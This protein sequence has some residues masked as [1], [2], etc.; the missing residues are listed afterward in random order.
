MS[1][2]PVDFQNYQMHQDKRNCFVIMPLGRT[3]KNHDKKYWEFFYEFV[4]LPIIEINHQQKY[5]IRYES[6]KPKEGRENIM[7]DVIKNLVTADLVIGILTDKNA[8][9]WY[10]LG[11]RHALRKPTIMVMEEE[12][13]IPFD[14]HQYGIAIYKENMITKSR[15]LPFIHYLT[16][17]ICMLRGIHNKLYENESKELE[18]NGYSTLFDHHNRKLY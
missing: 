12:E 8:N 9:V 11:I 10:E 13:E 14:I 1:N 15:L 2:S 18:K 5:Q 7:K 16:A 17:P 3:I 4:L 6:K